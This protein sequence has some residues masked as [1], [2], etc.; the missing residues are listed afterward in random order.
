MDSDSSLLILL[1]VDD[2]GEL[3][4]TQ[5]APTVVSERGTPDLRVENSMVSY[6]NGTV[7][8]H[9]VGNYKNNR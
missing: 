1:K 9:S 5:Q 8:I 2:V 7:S 3:C 6:S 4:S